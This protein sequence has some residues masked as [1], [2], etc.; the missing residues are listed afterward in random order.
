ME[1][2]YYTLKPAVG[3][4]ETGMAYP[5]VESYEDY[6]FKGA[7][8]VYK[9]KSHLPART[10]IDF[11]FKLAKKSR[12]TDFL[13]QV[14]IKGAGI[15]ISP[16]LFNFINSYKIIPYQ[17]FDVTIEAN[18]KF[19]NYK[20]LHFI[21]EDWH[22]YVDWKIS[23]FKL[24]ENFE[25]TSIEINSYKQYLEEVGKSEV[26]RVAPDKIVFFSID[27]DLFNHPFIGENVL[28]NRLKE[29]ISKANG[30]TGLEMSSVNF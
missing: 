22:E 2:Q 19:L 5:A 11:R 9:L 21:W 18:D 15:L 16:N 29:D 26:F 28:S 7:N 14:T 12:P 30:F 23:S 6:D 4:K 17:L 27:F 13:S 10:N 1:N 20:Y 8:S 3:T 24:F 25:F